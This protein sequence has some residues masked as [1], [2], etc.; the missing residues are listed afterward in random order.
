MAKKQKK[1]KSENDMTI[2]AEQ[3]QKF[4]RKARREADLEHSSFIRGGAHK[5]TKRDEVEDLDRTLSQ[6]ELQELI[7]EETMYYDG[8]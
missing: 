8:D 2:S 5:G 7:E 3:I 6:T 4:R 1:E